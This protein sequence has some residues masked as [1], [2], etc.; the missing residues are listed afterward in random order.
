MTVVLAGG[1]KLL[2][3]EEESLPL[4]PSLWISTEVCGQ[5]TGVLG[6]VSA[7]RIPLPPSQELPL[8]QDTLA[9]H[10]RSKA[11]GP[12]CHPKSQAGPSV[13]ANGCYKAVR[14]QRDLAAPLGCQ[15]HRF[16]RNKVWTPAAA[17]CWVRLARRFDAGQRMRQGISPC[18]LA[19]WGPVTSLSPVRGYHG[20]ASLTTGG[21]GDEEGP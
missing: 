5:L 16:F 6:G 11:L 17:S 20:D 2:L 7:P 12:S 4:P 1:S 15:A 9:P 13:N 21:R 10:P 8:F 18:S 3:A 14:R 19:T